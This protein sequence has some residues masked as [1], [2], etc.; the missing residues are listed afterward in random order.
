MLKDVEKNHLEAVG[1]LPDWQRNA[2]LLTP[3]DIMRVPSDER[4]DHVAVYADPS[5]PTAS[6]F[7]TADGDRGETVTVSGRSRVTVTG[8]QPTPGL[9][10]LSIKDDAGDDMAKVLA[11]VD[12]PHMYPVYPLTAVGRPVRYREYAM[13]AI[14]VDVEVFHDVEEWRKAQTPLNTSPSTQSI[15]ADDWPDEIY[16]G[17]TLV[18]SPWLFA[19]YGGQATA[20]E[21]SPLSTFKAVCREVAVATN[22]LTGRA[23]YRIEADCAF[24]VTLALPIDMTP[25]P[26]VGSVVDGEVILTGTTGFW[27]D[28]ATDRS[29]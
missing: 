19:L 9:A 6:F 20:E 10:E 2:K 12:D 3:S 14:A 23:W 7:Q 4:W 18:T 15:S 21:A 29:A 8:W 11:W 28:D 27:L 13:G 24:P 1:F 17:P 22:H 16:I 5:G 26:R 25:A